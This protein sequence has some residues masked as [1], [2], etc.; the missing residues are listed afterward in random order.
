MKW[1]PSPSL[2]RKVKLLFL[3]LVPY[4][5]FASE[6][7]GY[8]QW[9]ISRAKKRS[10]VMI[11]VVIR[12][13]NSDFWGFE[14]MT[15]N[16]SGGA[17]FN[18]GIIDLVRLV[19]PKIGGNL[20]SKRTIIIICLMI[21]FVFLADSF[22]TFSRATIDSM[23]DDGNHHRWGI[24]LRLLESDRLGGMFFNF[25]GGDD[26]LIMKAQCPTEIFSLQYAGMFG[27]PSSKSAVVSTSKH[28]HRVKLFSVQ[29]FT[30]PCLRPVMPQWTHPRWFV[31]HISVKSMVTCSWAIHRID[32]SL[33]C[34]LDWRSF[35]DENCIMATHWLSWRIFN[36]TILV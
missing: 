10:M 17:C 36:W 19:L 24:Q 25:V 9:L 31:F 16:L 30:P 4:G 27:S 26:W 28:W 35:T 15:G 6:R 2:I 34:F 7:A 11:L 13:K 29:S 23:I 21:S 22:V 18:R 12:R 3:S 33:Q 14:T 20:E 1:V 5:A 32:H 8:D